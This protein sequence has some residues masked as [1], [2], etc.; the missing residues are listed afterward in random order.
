M[1]VS[2]GGFHFEDSILNGEERHVKSATT[3]IED[4]HV[5]LALAL[6]VKTVGNGGGSGLVDDTGDVE[7]SDCASVLSGLPLGV[8]EVSGDCDDSTT[9][10]LA[11]ISLSNLLHLDEDHGGDFFGLEL[12][13]LAFKVDDNHGLLAGARLDLER[14]EGDVFLD[15]AVAELAADKTLGVED[16]VCWVS[17][18]LVLG[19]VTDK[20]L[21]LGECDVG[22]RGIDTLIVGDDLDLFI[23]PDTDAGVRGAQIN[24]D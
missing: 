7:T 21:L 3:K 6:L 19:G 8:V 4:E 5:S 12:L 16:S 20:T 10:C 18:G 24:S 13:L 14:P 9:D 2:V 22:R 23:L 11:K 17:C 1:S 15:S